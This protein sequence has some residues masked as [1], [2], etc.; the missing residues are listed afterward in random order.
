MKT[1]K[2]KTNETAQNIEQDGN[3]NMGRKWCFS[4]LNNFCQ[5][6]YPY[7]NDIVV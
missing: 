7:D 4:I 5:L 2:R 1:Q 3:N 6:F